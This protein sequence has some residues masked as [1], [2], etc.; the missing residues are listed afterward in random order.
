MSIIRIWVGAT[1][2][3]RFTIIVTTL[4]SVIKYNQKPPK[5]QIFWFAKTIRDSIDYAV[6]S[7]VTAVALEAWGRV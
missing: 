5:N 3:V 1:R 4:V 2:T 6:V 7:E